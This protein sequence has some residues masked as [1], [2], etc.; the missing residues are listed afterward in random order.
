VSTSCVVTDLVRDE[1]ALTLEASLTSQ[2]EPSHLPVQYAAVY[3]EPR[4]AGVAAT[5]SIDEASI[6]VS[7]GPPGDEEED[8]VPGQD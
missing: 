1:Y 4:K 3:V 8:G 2:H 5:L 6:E 7:A